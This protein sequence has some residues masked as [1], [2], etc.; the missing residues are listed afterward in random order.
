MGVI[1][2]R[3]VMAIQNIKLAPAYLFFGCRHPDHDFLYRDQLEKWDEDVP[4][5][6]DA[7]LRK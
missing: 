6:R 1:E 5:S 3:A 4:F 7:S 2:E